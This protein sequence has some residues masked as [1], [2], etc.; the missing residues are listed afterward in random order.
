MKT[1]RITMDDRIEM[2]L[3]SGNRDKQNKLDRI[4]ANC[5]F[6]LANSDNAGLKHFAEIIK[7]MTI[8]T[9]NQ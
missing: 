8:Q 5:D 4:A 3:R 6:A 7:L 2:D 1:Q 9:L